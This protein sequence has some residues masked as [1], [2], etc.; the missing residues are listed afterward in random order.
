MDIRPVPLKEV[1]MLRHAVMYPGYPEAVVKLKDDELGTHLG[2]YKDG[3][4]A[5][6]V[7]V[8]QQGREMQF[9]N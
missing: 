7:S 4:L 6:V 2:I 5:S 1:W 9:R 3:E 8:F